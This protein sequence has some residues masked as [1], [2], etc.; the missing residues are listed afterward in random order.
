MQQQQRLPPRPA[1]SR[2]RARGCG[3][4]LPE[5]TRRPSGPSPPTSC[6][7]LPSHPPRACPSGH[8]LLAASLLAAAAR[9]I[10]LGGTCGPAALYSPLLIRTCPPAGCEDV[11]WVRAAGRGRTAISLPPLPSCPSPTPP[12]PHPRDCGVGT[13]PKPIVFSDPAARNSLS[14]MLGQRH[15]RV[16]QPP[17]ASYLSQRFYAQPRFPKSAD[18]DTYVQ[19]QVS[20]HSTRIFALPLRLER[21][22]I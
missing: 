5:G 22:F 19:E 9:H 4:G 1:S 7:A 17:A 15:G 20:S 21:V 6:P 13:Q 18:Q 3:E 14:G 16:H 12:S 8:V 2:G 11:L 10:R